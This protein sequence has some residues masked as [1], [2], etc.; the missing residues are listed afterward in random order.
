MQFDP[1]LFYRTRTLRTYTCG[2]LVLAAPFIYRRKGKV[3]YADIYIYIYMHCY[4]VGVLAHDE[5]SV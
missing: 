2:F 5:E 1:L 4:V 3:T